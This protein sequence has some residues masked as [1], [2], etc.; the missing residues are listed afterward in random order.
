VGVDRAVG[1]L[2]RSRRDWRDDDDIDR[3]WDLAPLAVMQATMEAEGFTLSVIEDNPPMDR[4]RLGRP[5]REEEIEL[6]RTLLRSMGKLG[7]PVLCYNWSAVV[8]WVRTELAMRGRGG[9]IVPAS[10]T[11]G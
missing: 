1:V 2:P 6:F 10:T 4:I 8:G 7:I 3:P 5:G 9:A 11:P